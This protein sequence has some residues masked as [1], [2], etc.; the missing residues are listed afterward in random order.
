MDQFLSNLHTIDLSAA[1]DEDQDGLIEINPDND[2]SNGHLADLLKEN[3]KA[4]AN[5]IKL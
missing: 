5:L 3:I 4:A 1:N 2:D